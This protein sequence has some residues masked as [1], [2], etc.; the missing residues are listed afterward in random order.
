MGHQLF[1]HDVFQLF[2]R[3]ENSGLLLGQIASSKLR[4][5]QNSGQ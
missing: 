2:P 1:D 5:W 4:R 3:E